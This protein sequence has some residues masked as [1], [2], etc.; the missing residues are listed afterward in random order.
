MGL[1]QNKGPVLTA[2]G[3]QHTKR[4]KRA[5]KEAAMLVVSVSLNGGI[6]R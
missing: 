4:L 6:G 5:T 2:A 3:R 1:K